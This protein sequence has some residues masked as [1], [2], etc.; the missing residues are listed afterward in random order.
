MRRFLGLHHGGDPAPIGSLGRC[1]RR[2]HGVHKA[3]DGDDED[4]NEEDKEG[5]RP[6]PPPSSFFSSSSS[7][8]PSSFFFS[9]SSSSLLL[10]LVNKLSGMGNGQWTMEVDPSNLHADLI[11]Y[12]W[13]AA[14]L[15]AP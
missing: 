1:V 8:S 3:H 9:F 5:Q 12:M 4:K 15:D 11:D 10:L 2:S 6:P 14:L 13:R 7:F